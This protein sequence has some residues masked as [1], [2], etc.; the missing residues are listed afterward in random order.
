MII[1]LENVR[2]ISKTKYPI[3]DR[4]IFEPENKWDKYILEESIKLKLSNG[5][6]LEIEKGFKWDKSSMPKI[7][8]A[9]FAPTGKFELAALIH[10]KIYADLNHVYS[11]KFADK[12]MYLWS[13]A[14]QGTSKISFRNFDNWFRYIGARAVGWLAWD[15]II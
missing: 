14:L 3:L 7:F 6:V 1:T 2:D 4:Q 10:D 5:D 9:V 11:R 15:D 13:K 8:H 12:E